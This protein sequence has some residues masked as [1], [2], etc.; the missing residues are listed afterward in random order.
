MNIILGVIIFSIILV[1]ILC[2]ALWYRNEKDSYSHPPEPVGY[3]R[4]MFRDVYPSQSRVPIREGRESYTMNKNAITLCLRD[5]KSKKIYPWNTLAY[6]SLHELA[7]V[8]TRVREKDE[9]GPVFRKNFK[10]LLKRAQ[11]LGYYDPRQEVPDT[12]CST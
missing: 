3:I 12:Y 9:H 7:H 10:M 4:K 11:T 6:V 8:I 2:L 1:A 5:P